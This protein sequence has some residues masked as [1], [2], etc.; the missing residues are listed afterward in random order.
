LHHVCPAYRSAPRSHALYT[1]HQGWLQAWLR[2]KLGNAHQAADLAHDTFV[3][4]Q[5]QGAGA[6]AR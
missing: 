6:G 5:A 3:C 4:L 1:D 2:K